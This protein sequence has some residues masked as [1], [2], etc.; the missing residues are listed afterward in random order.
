MSSSGSYMR[1]WRVI[2]LLTLFL[3]IVGPWN[4]ERLH[5]PAKY[6]CTPPNV[7]LEGDFCGSPVSGMVILAWIVGWFLYAVVGLFTGGTSL[8]QA[9]SELLS[10]LLV[11]LLL[12]LLLE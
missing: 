3:G 12:F 7:R 2:I 8:A 9:G 6:P 4:Y 1:V 10:G 11:N 5:V